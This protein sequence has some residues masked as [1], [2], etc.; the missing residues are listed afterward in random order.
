[1]AAPQ[2]KKKVRKMI[3]LDFPF[4]LEGAQ[5]RQYQPL[6]SGDTKHPELT[7]QVYKNNKII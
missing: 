7:N 1:M 6:S 4:F 3:W 2:G 5:K